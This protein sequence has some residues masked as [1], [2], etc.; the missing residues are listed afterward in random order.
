MSLI[1][2]MSMKG[3]NGFFHE[4]RGIILDSHVTSWSKRAKTGT[5]QHSIFSGICWLS[6]SSIEVKRIV[7]FLPTFN[8]ACG[9]RKI[10]LSL[11]FESRP[12]AL[13][14]SFLSFH[15]YSSAAPSFLAMSQAERLHKL[16]EEGSAFYK[17]NQLLEGILLSF[18]YSPLAANLRSNQEIPGSRQT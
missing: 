7:S 5:C 12:L 17:P 10:T 18:T 6:Q 11:T 2:H 15:V 4:W 8:I 3:S 16:R 13:Q 1:D 9:C 14:S